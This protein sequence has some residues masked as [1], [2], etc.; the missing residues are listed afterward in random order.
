MTRVYWDSM[1]FIYLLEDHPKYGER[2][3]YLLEQAERRGH[4][5]CTSTLTRGEVLTGVYM[6]GTAEEA[7]RI[8]E[9]LRP[10][11]VELLPFTADAA[12][13]FARIRAAQKVAPAD[14]IHL[15]TAAEAGVQL[16]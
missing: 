4:S 7:A 14:A 2:I 12:N 3:R 16:F 5:L 13:R 6:R 11:L 15:A 9:L 10:P 8:L 1:M